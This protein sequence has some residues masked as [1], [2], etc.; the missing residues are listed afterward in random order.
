LDTF[1]IFTIVGLTTAAIYAVIASGLVLTYT[2]TGVF[3]F[4]HGAAGM[5]AAFMYWQLTVAWGWPTPLAIVVILFGLA[6][7]FGILL[8]GVIFRGLEGTSEA[9]KLVVSI[10]LLV[11]MIGLSQWIWGPS[12]ARVVPPFFASDKFDLAGATITYHQ[13][14]TIIVAIAVAVG[15]RILLY[16]TRI[17]VAMRA[18]VDDRPLAQLNGARTPMVSRTSWAVGTSLA[19]LGG[20]LIASSAGM[21]A[22]TLSLLIVNAYGAALFGRL[23]SLPWTF[24]GAVVLGLTDG[25]L[26]G[27]VPSSGVAGPYLAG[28]RLASPVILLFVVLLV[29]PSRQLRSHVQARE[30]FPA[31]TARGVGMFCGFSLLFGLILATTLSASDLPQYSQMFSYGIIALS[32]VLLVGF[33][34]Q[35]SLCQFSFAGIGAIVMAHLGSGGNPLGLVAAVVVAAAVGALVALPVLRLSGIYLALATAAF[36]VLLDR[37]LFQLPDWSWGPLHISL[38]ASGTLQVDTLKVFGYKFTSGTSLMILAVVLFVLVAL[39]VVGVRRSAYGRRLLAMR[40]SEAACATFGLNLTATRLSVFVLSAAIA[41]LGGAL[42][43]L[44]L[45]A[46]SPSNFDFVSGLPIFMLVVVG[47][48]GFVG[49]ALFTGVSLQGLLPALAAKWTFFAKV[50]TMLPGLAGI[51]LGRQPSGASP[52]FSA[53]FAPLRDDTPVLATMVGGIVVVWILRLAG[54]IDN[55]PMVMLF[56]VLV[57]AAMVAVRL[58]AGAGL[59]ARAARAAMTGAPA[60]PAPEAAATPGPTAPAEPVA[61]PVPI[62]WVG[63]TVPW[64]PE[65]LAEV[66]EHLALGSIPRSER[67]PA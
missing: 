23:R 28:L 63:L 67:A 46:I 53:G 1:L 45:S 4:A 52:Q 48:A 11:A 59:Y 5:L 19:A 3:N 8:E 12:I 64:T 2:T 15:L 14:I 20:I 61:A 33:A 65:R 36:A 58:R 13:L 57:V 40:D 16:R 7:A 56:A 30:Y 21:N 24:V 17:G 60:E 9:T 29:L 39:L 42:L 51:G 54:A 10:S 6:P 44:Q 34:G 55:W 66:E 38:F 18:V 37:W 41:G 32:L 43:A 22:A 27:Y 31:P 49:A 50:Q 47:G 26:A 35:I 62:E 25:Y